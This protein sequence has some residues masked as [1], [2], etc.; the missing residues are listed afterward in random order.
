MAAIASL[1]TFLF[2]CQIEVLIKQILTRYSGG[3][4]ANR[5]FIL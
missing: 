1:N 2:F 3:K 4:L 5:T